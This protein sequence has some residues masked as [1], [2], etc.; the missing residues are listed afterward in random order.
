M[1]IRAVEN[2]YSQIATKQAPQAPPGMA[3]TT[4][5]PIPSPGPA[6]PPI[7]RRTAAIPPTTTV[8]AHDQEE[9]MYEDLETGKVRHLDYILDQ[10]K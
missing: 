4:R 1:L 2:V 5:P 8:K 9:E 7:V 3:D 6:A 10:Y